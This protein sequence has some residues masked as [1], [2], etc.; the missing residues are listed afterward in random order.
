MEMR[1]R[2]VRHAQTQVSDAGVEF[3]DQDEIIVRRAD[4]LS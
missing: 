2:K 4:E 1:C 3:S